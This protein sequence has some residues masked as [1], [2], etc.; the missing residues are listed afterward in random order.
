MRVL[1]TGGA[2]F[3]G[4]HLVD[5]FL[6]EGFQVRVLDSLDPK[7]HS[8]GLPT[9]VPQGVEFIKGDVRNREMLLAAL[10]NVDI[11]S[12]QAAYQDYM[13]DFSRFLHVNAVGTALIYEL[14]V[15]Q[16]L[17]V[18]KVIVASS[19]AVY[20]EGQYVCSVHGF[21]QPSPRSQEQLS[22]GQWE[23]KCPACDRP[24][25]SCLHEENHTNPY[26]QYAVSK[27]AEEK[28]ALGLGWLHGIPSVALRYS[29][30]QGP[31]QSLFNQ[32]S[33]VCRIFIGRA[34]KGE[35]LIVYEDGLQSRDFVHVKDVVDA[36]M[37][38][39]ASDEANFQAFNVGSGEP[40]TILE[41]A[42][43][44]RRKL[45]SDVEINFSGEF[46]RGDNRNSVSRVDKLKAL[47]WRPKHDLST[48]LDDFLAWVESIGGIPVH[49]QDAYG[50]MRNAGVVL[51]ATV[52]C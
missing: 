20:G 43:F 25:K 41:Y 18:K 50:T 34:L 16:K 46:R 27:L 42:N 26:N 13:P 33:G 4:S 40:I 48:I 28:I 1:V 35:S 14:I 45:M 15:E 30:T 51:R 24:A 17:K 52:G 49:I 31:R 5:R 6:S 32:Y 29:I 8:E 23:V 39:L 12:H 11:V 47:G 10:Q 19:Q 44:V 37:H 36:N 2:G 7:I 3:I 38:V 22:R 21:F 9:N